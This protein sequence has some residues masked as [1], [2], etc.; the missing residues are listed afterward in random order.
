MAAAM[1]LFGAFLAVLPA[2]A[3]AQDAAD[4]LLPPGLGSPAEEK[5]KPESRL[6][7]F[8][9]MNI[10]TSKNRQN[11]GMIISEAESEAARQTGRQQGLTK[12]RTPE[13]LEREIRDEAFK[14]AVSGLLPMRPDEIRRLLEYYD[15][16]RQAVETPLY[17]TPEPQVKVETVSLDPGV[18]PPVV[19]LAMSHIT[20]I[21]IYDVTGAPWPIQD[22]SWAG[23]FKV[24]EPEKGGHILRI[25]PMGEFAQGNLSLRLITLKT[26]IIFSL[27]TSRERVHY[28]FDAR[29]PE[30]GPFA[31]API[32]RGQT[33]TAS[34]G[35]GDMTAFLEGVIPS[36]AARLAV[37]GVD[38]RTTAYRYN[39]RT[40]VRTPYT[41]LSPAWQ[42]SVRSG[43]GMTVYALANTPVLL[44]SDKGQVLRANVNQED[45]P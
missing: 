14:A 3:G 42:S 11:P 19:E 32:I 4:N 37:S 44:L 25:T 18:Q 21:S 12:P 45:S 7:Q 28:R 5:E 27:E 24:I 36:G 33:A 17:P 16:T 22:V 23:N 38:G 1:F 31:N 35:D 6:K 10:G 29:I 39:S 34:A 13:Q 26:P 30:Y 20:T 15:Q 9:H 40:Y 2:S 41:L 43:D 8:E